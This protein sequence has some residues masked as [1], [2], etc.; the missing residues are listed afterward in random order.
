MREEVFVVTLA[1][2]LIFGVMAVAIVILLA[3]SKRQEPQGPAGSEWHLELWNIYYGYQ[4]ELRFVNTFVLGRI[5]LFDNIVG[6][7]PSMADET[8]SREHCML[9]DQNGTLL[10]WNMSAINPAGINGYR[11]NVPRE[12]V[13]GDRLE[14]GNSVFLI[15]RVERTA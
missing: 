8:I 6:S 3:S 11:L 7:M 15:T 2:I 9:Y 1:V 12:V 10:I 5:S 13:P 14:M 4:V